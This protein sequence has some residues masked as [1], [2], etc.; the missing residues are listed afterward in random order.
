MRF[1]QIE[2]H[3]THKSYSTPKAPR[4]LRKINIHIHHI[5]SVMNGGLNLVLEYHILLI[6]ARKLRGGGQGAFDKDGAKGFDAGL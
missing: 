2:P 4:D 5:L 1:A 6:F 3:H